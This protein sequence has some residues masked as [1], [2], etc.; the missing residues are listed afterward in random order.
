MRRS[1]PIA[2]LL[3]SCASAPPREEPFAAVVVETPPP[4]P[5]RV[6]RPPLQIAGPARDPNPP[7]STLLPASAFVDPSPPEGWSQCAGF[8]NGPG[9]DVSER[10][11]DG[12]LETTRLRVRVFTEGGRLEE[13]LWVERMAPA[14]A[15]PR[16]SYLAGEGTAEVRTSWGSLEGGAVSLLFAD[17]DGLDACHQPSAPG[18]PT[19]GSGHA[20]KAIIAPGARDENEYRISCGGAPLL[21]RSIAIYR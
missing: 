14:A 3:L 2:A 4:R 7:G 18:G 5:G 9:D 11:L 1:V 16:L 17:A 10:F 15:W 8:V 13:D 20:K 6:E 12:C 19:L 21:G